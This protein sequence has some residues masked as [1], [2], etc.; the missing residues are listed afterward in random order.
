MNERELLLKVADHIERHPGSYSFKKIWM[1]TKINPTGCLI[2]WMAHFAGHWSWFGR[3]MTDTNKSMKLIG[4]DSRTFFNRLYEF[5][6][7]WSAF[8][9]DAVSALRQYADKYHPDAYTK[10]RNSLILEPLQDD[11]TTSV[12]TLLP[13][14]G[15]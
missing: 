12:Q 15:R 7:S 4:V 10:F 5:N 3:V 13:I 2:G 8:S 11:Q 6:M 14:E 9:H 1:P